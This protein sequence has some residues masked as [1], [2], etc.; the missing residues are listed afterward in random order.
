MGEKHE[1]AD[2][3]EILEERSHLHLAIIS[4]PTRVIHDSGENGKDDEHPGRLTFPVIEHEHKTATELEDDSRDECDG[5]Y[6]HRKTDITETDFDKTDHVLEIQKESEATDDEEEREEDT[7]PVLLRDTAF[8]CAHHRIKILR[9]LS[10]GK[11]IVF[12]TSGKGRGK[13]SL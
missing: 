4:A 2:D 1:S 8:F 6:R 10:Y 13:R 3:G 11:Y 5:R 7:W 12:P 9:K